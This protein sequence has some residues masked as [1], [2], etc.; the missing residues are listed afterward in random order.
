METSSAQVQ[1]ARQNLFDYPDMHN[2][3]FKTVSSLDRFEECRLE[4]VPQSANL[5]AME[6][7]LCITRDGRYQ[8]YVAHGGLA[9]AVLSISEAEAGTSRSTAQV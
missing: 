6:I 7:A 8:T 4:V 3:I 9:L 5:V 2:E 1:N